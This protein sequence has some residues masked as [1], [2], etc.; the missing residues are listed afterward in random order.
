MTIPDPLV[1]PAE[2]TPD[3]AKL[4]AMHAQYVQGG[5]STPENE[6]ARLLADITAGAQ[7]DADFWERIL[8][9]VMAAVSAKPPTDD[10][11]RPVAVQPRKGSKL[12][13]LHARYFE[14]KE[15]R[16]AAVEAFDAVAAEIKSELG[17]K[18]SEAAAT[19]VELQ[20]PAGRPLR[21]IYAESWRVD[22]TRLK[23]EDPHTYVKWAKKSG[24]WSLTEG[25]G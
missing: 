5:L 7:I 3:R 24:S 17:T 18:A 10:Q 9:E 21:L 23:R 4:L 2:I 22:S 1:D 13:A 16:N 25:K 19:K 15:A 20:S 12:E 11:V 14:L 8:S 6:A